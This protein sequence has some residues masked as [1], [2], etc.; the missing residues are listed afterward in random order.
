MRAIKNVLLYELW[1]INDLRG[2]KKP[3]FL[4]KEQ[5]LVESGV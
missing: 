4:W 1:K 3:F 5:F 2:K